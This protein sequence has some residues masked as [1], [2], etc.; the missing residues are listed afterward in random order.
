MAKHR[1]FNGD[2]FLDKFHGQEQLL[3]DFAALWRDRL[4]LD[5]EAFTIDEFK[6][7]LTE[8]TDDGK[9]DLLETLYQ[10]YDLCTEA[11]H[12]DLIA[13]CEQSNYEPDPDND[14]PVECLALLVRT[15]RRLVFLLAYDRYNFSNAERF[16][17]LQGEC[18]RPIQDLKKATRK[19]KQRLASEFK[20]VKNSER[21][22]V[23][24]YE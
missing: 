1:T 14:L 2:K 5:V 22:L 3:R 9:D 23:R 8:S 24:S 11:G 19:L 18:G 15:Q 17:I 20:K 12:L 16:S 13:S 21:V 10:V 7:W 4:T 6:T